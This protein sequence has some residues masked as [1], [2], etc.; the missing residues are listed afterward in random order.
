VI[1][2]RE[3]AASFSSGAA[4]SRLDSDRRTLGN[5]NPVLL[6]ACRPGHNK[7]YRCPG[8]SARE[9]L[10]CRAGPRNW[11]DSVRLGG[12]L[13][14]PYW[15]SRSRVQT[16]ILQAQPENIATGTRSWGEMSGADLK[17]YALVNGW[18][19]CLPLSLSDLER[20]LR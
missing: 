10:V 4:A 6:E 18:H 13:T 3:E 20:S 12:Q 1:R 15:A 19:A 2:F 11:R 7:R 16:S 5:W 14:C 8:T 9:V 17:L